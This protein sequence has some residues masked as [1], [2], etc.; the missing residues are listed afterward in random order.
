M[1]SVADL[2]G[3]LEQPH[4]AWH[5]GRGA[6]NLDAVKIEAYL[7]DRVVR[8]FSAPTPWAGAGR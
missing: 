8:K 6:R 4:F 3:H 5:L 7:L 2:V 1:G